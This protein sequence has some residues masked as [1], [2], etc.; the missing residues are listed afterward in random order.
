[1]FG[2]QPAIFDDPKNLLKSVPIPKRVHVASDLSVRPQSNASGKQTN[3]SSE[4][5]PQYTDDE[6]IFSLETLRAP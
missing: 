1:M 5:G 3:N 4:D 6:L 2:T